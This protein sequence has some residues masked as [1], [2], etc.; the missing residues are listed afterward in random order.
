MQLLHFLFQGTVL[1][2]H[3]LI[4]QFCHAKKDEQMLKK[5]DKDKSSSKLLVRNV[6]FEA[7]EKDLRQ[8]FSPFGQVI[9][10]MNLIIV[11]LFTHINLI[12]ECSCK[13]KRLGSFIAITDF[14]IYILHFE[15]DLRNQ[16]AR[17][18][19]CCKKEQCKQCIIKTSISYLLMSYISTSTS[20]FH[21]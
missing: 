15:I 8:L 19:E 20:F 16:D 17:T 11:H 1:D 10:C 3:A 14:S 5:V 13:V 2:G 4:L 18:R 7:T 12:I 6:A 9:T 21:N